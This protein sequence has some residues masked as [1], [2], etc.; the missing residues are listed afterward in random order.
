MRNKLGGVL[1]RIDSCRNC[2]N[3]LSVIELCPDC[4]QPMHFECGKCIKFV[5]NQIHSHQNFL[6][7]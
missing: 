2:G 4:R 3:G 5:D 7:S 1:M 6:F